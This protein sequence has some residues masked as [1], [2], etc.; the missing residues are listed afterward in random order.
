MHNH[1]PYARII[2]NFVASATLVHVATM[3]KREFRSINLQSSFSL[4]LSVITANQKVIDVN[5]KPKSAQQMVSA[6]II[7]NMKRLWNV[8]LVV[9]IER[10]RVSTYFRNVTFCVL[11]KTGKLMITRS[12]STVPV[13]RISETDWYLYDKNFKISFLSKTCFTH[14][15]VSRRMFVSP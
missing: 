2:C 9:E 3:R 10:F 1:V 11:C 5:R 12:W 6:W 8:L 15:D 4:Y 13:Q 14:P 7:I